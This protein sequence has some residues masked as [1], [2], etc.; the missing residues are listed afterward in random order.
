M[1]FLG[2]PVKN[3]RIYCELRDI[4][5]IFKTKSL[6]ITLILRGLAVGLKQAGMGNNVRSRPPA[7][8]PIPPAIA[9]AETLSR[10]VIASVPH[11]W[12]IAPL[13]AGHS[14]AK[15]L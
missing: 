2:P 5:W 7:V 1:T 10:G 4:I 13:E 6:S 11:A 3:I 12:R 14:L 8:P 15:V 9:L